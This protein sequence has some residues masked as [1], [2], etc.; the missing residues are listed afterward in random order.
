MQSH[1]ARTNSDLSQFK[2]L[3]LHQLLFSKDYLFIALGNI[4]IKKLSLRGQAYALGSPGKQL[5]FQGFF[6]LLHGLTFYLAPLSYGIPS[7]LG[8]CEFLDVNA[9]MIMDAINGI[10]L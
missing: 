1:I 10:I 5:R 8:A 3:H 4:G 9:R 7:A 2:I 6:Q